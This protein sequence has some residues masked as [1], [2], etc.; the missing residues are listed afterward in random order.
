MDFI[1]HS[2]R[3]G[4]EVIRSNPGLTTLWQGLTGVIESVTDEEIIAAFQQASRKAKSISDAVN[5]LL[6]E[7]LVQGG[8]RRQSRIFKD[9]DTYKGTTWTLDF[10]KNIDESEGAPTGMAVEVVFNH[11]EAIAWNLI[12]LSL[13]AEM[14]H[15]RKETD[16]SR[17]V[18]VYVCATDAMKQAGGFDGAVGEYEKVLKYLDPLSQVIVTPLIIIGLEPPKSFRVKHDKDPSTKKLRGRIARL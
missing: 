9:Q 17:G 2:Y 13:A 10:S 1:T 11:G 7:R 8:C 5:D 18:G 15:V 12:K 4:I 3:H 14:N 6:D 16:I